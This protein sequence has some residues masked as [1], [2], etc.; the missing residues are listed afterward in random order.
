VTAIDGTK[1]SANASRDR[2]ID[3]AQL[4]QLIVE[5][6]IA[7]DAADAADAAAL[8]AR[9]GDELPEIVRAGEGRQAWLRA[10]RQRL[11]QERAAC[12][13]PIPRS[14]E[15]RVLRPSGGSRRSWRLSGAAMSATRPTGR[16]E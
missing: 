16:A 15:R 2:T 9:S 10:A 13:E 7:T 3:C 1:V 6:A 14:R 8:G 12:Q 11:D 4:A 5:E